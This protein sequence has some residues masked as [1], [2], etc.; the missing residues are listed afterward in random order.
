MDLR[1]LD[2]GLLL[3]GLLGQLTLGGAELA[4]V[5]VRD[6][7]RVEDLGLGDLVRPGLDHQDRVLGAGDDQIEVGAVKQ[8]LFVGVDDEV[9]VDLADPNRTDR[10]GER[11][12]GDHQSRGGAV[13]RQHVVRVDV[14]N[15][16]RQRDQLGLVSPA[17]G[18]QR[19]DRS[20]DQARGQRPLLAGA[21][22]AL[23]E[24]A[25]DLPR[26]VHPLLDVD[27]ERQKISVAEVSGGRGRE[28]H[29][30]ALADHDGPAGLLC[31]PSGF[32]R[33]LAPGDLHGEPGESVRH[34]Q[35]P[36]CSALRSAKCFVSL[37]YSER[38]GW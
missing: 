11:D 22:L 9:A 25:G 38:P 15:R 37:I 13:Q 8:R 35:F 23:K 3:A 6:V 17:L 19:A 29:R 5:L 4:N 16:H 28:D 12:V 14:V 33:D 24:R 7:E 1:D 20:V 30:V 26:G 27:G 36:S 32:E 18:E 2:L 10:A 34:I 21:P 31:D